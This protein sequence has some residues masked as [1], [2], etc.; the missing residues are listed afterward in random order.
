MELN[1][2]K[3]YKI[4]QETKTIEWLVENTK[5]RTFNK[6]T[7][8]GYQRQVNETHVDNIIKYLETQ[9][10]YLPTSIICA[11]KKDIKEYYI[12]DGQHRIEAFKRLKNKNEIKYNEIKDF[13]LSIILLVDPPE[14]LEVDTFITINKT[15]KKVDTSLAYILKNKLNKLK[16]NSSDDLSITKKEFLAVE[17]A[18]FLNKNDKE[19]WKDKILFEGN[20]SNK[21][22]ETISLNSFVRTTRVFISYLEK[23]KIISLNWNDNESLDNIL[24]DISEI[25]LSLWKAIKNKWPDLFFESD[26]KK[27][28]IQGTIGVTALNKYLILQLKNNNKSYNKNELINDIKNWIELIDIQSKKW[29]SG[30]DFSKF[31]SEAGFSTVADIL[32]KSTI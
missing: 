31:S 10:F 9:P 11:S 6:V 27:N 22:F 1:Q 12:V 21:S 20:P 29:Y 2:D 7:L 26:S 4:L 23:Y 30:E 32:Y 15:A 24:N 8:E 25:Y 3:K 28:V 13:N 14:E 18:E 16:N 19:F 17:L 5:V